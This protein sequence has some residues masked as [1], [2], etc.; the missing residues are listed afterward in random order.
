MEQIG[1]IKDAE[2]LSNKK[3][4][5][6]LESIENHIKLF[7]Y[8]RFELCWRNVLENEINKRR[9]EL[10]KKVNLQEVK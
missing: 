6:E 5:Q 3:L 8:G 2:R 7:S 10:T 1:L 4:L 9:L